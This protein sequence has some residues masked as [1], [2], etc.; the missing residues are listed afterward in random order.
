MGN[1]KYIVYVN[2]QSI[3]PLVNSIKDAK[4]HAENHKKYKPSLRIECYSSPITA[5]VWI[6][7]Y[8]IEAWVKIADYHKPDHCCL[9]TDCQPG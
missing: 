5:C 2:E 8:N 4:L 7:D 9:A 3:K 6:Y 1:M